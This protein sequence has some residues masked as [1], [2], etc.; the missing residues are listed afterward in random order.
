MDL[1]CYRKGADVDCE[2]TLVAGTTV[3][4]RC[5]PQHH[6]EYPVYYRDITCQADGEWTNPLFA[7]A[8]GN[9][10]E[11][12]ENTVNIYLYRPIIIL[13]SKEEARQFFNVFFKKAGSMNNN[14]IFV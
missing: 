14:H 11:N 12:N 4:P 2:G 6:E 8:P 10:H 1:V 3:R 7:C 13:S 5:K 9:M